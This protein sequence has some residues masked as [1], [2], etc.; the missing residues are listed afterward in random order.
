MG[1]R[2]NFE[3]TWEQAL[4]RAAMFDNVEVIPEQHVL[5]Q[6]KSFKH[7]VFGELILMF[8]PEDGKCNLI[9]TRYTFSGF[10][11]SELLHTVEQWGRI[12]KAGYAQNINVERGL[13]TCTYSRKGWLERVALSSSAQTASQ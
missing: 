7:I 6:T 8:D 1:I 13:I 5:I 10:G 12:A 9:T 11:L 2:K 3:L 4:F